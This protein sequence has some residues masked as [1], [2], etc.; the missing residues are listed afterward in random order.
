MVAF[1][2]EAY[3]A[4]CVFALAVFLAWAAVAKLRPDLDEEEFDLVEVEKLRKP[5][6]LEPFG[7]AL[8]IEPSII[9]E[10]SWSSPAVSLDGA[11]VAKLRPN[12][13]EGESGLAEL[14]MLKKLVSLEPFG[15]ALSIEPLI[16]EEASWS[17]PERRAKK[18][19]R[20]MR[21]RSHLFHTGNPRAI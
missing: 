5:A 6:S 9:E 17:Q 10:A 3:G 20:S 2:F 21:G 8:S 12:L 15:D 11:A 16:I 18:S 13:D 1:V 4:L 19:K 14:E 7:D